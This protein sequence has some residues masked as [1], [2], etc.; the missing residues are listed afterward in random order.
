M[1]CKAALT[2]FTRDYNFSKLADVWASKV[3]FSKF[4]VDEFYKCKPSAF[5]V[6][7]SRFY[8]SKSKVKVVNL[9]ITLVYDFQ[10]VVVKIVPFNSLV[11]TCSFAKD[12]SRPI[13][14]VGEECG[15]VSVL[16]LSDLKNVQWFKPNFSK[17]LPVLLADWLDD[18]CV[19]F[20]FQKELHSWNI[21]TGQ[22]EIVHQS[23]NTI[24]YFTCSPFSPSLA[25]ELLVIFKMAIC[26]EKDCIQKNQS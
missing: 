15:Q 20:S 13:L 12:P 4:E 5:F 6:Y 21:E 24:T 7:S 10:P 2:G 14:F 3:Y 22:I 1:E 16:D 11:T 9:V 25:G 19:L 18:K 23:A 26:V 8:F 17:R